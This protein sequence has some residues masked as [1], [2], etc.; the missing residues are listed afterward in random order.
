MAICSCWCCADA[1]IK[2]TFSFIEK[3]LRM[4]EGNGFTSSSAIMAE[5][6]VNSRTIDATWFL[7][8]LDVCKGLYYECCGWMCARLSCNLT[9]FCSCLLLLP[10][11]RDLQVT[12][13][14]LMAVQA[15]CM[16]LCPASAPVQLW[17]MQMLLAKVSCAFAPLNCCG[18]CRMLL[19]NINS[20]HHTLQHSS[21]L[22]D[23]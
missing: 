16:A 17:H 23:L 6:G 3:R 14:S 5:S 8:I 4:C 7:P 13:A 11:Q 9:I 20:R 1:H 21:G 12:R 10:L 15:S 19:V 22:H 2:K 18:A